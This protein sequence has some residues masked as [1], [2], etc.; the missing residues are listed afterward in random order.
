MSSRPDIEEALNVRSYEQVVV[1]SNPES[2]YEYPEMW[3]RPKDASGLSAIDDC[4]VVVVDR[5]EVSVDTIAK[6]GEKRARILAFAPN[7]VEQEKTMRRALRAAYP[8]AEVW[9]LYTTSG[10][11]LFTKD[12]IGKSYD[13]DTLIDMRDA[14]AV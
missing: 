9:E 12:A 14:E 3:V 11:V 1:L 7:G 10:K 13:R 2:E 4:T 8:W 6:I 5:V